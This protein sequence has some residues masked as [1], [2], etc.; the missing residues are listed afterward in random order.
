MEAQTEIKI[1]GRNINDLRYADD[2]TLMAQSEEELNSL[3]MK[4]K[5]ALVSWGTFILFSTVVVPIHI[6][7]NSAGGSLLSIPSPT[8]AISCCFDSS[9]QADSWLHSCK[10]VGHGGGNYPSSL[11]LSPPP[12]PAMTPASAPLQGTL[13]GLVGTGTAILSPWG[14]GS[15]CEPKWHF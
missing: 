6:L 13:R 14:Q 1:A 9:S 7:T 15:H 4:V 5:E 12:S 11:S 2:T 3:L 10:N 8:L